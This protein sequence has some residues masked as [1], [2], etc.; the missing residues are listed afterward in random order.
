MTNAPALPVALL[1]AY[2]R[3]L[4]EFLGDL[5]LDPHLGFQT[6]LR[7]RLAAVSSPAELEALLRDLLG[8]SDTLITTEAERNRLGK[9]LKNKNLAGLPQ[10]R[11]ALGIRPSS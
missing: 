7:E 11:S 6:Y 8:W 2:A 9:A 10:L 1:T 5:A 4:V 3:C